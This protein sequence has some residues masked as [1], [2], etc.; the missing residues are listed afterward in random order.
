MD[1][2]EKLDNALR[3]SIDNFSGFHDFTVDTYDLIDTKSLEKIECSSNTYDEYIFYLWDISPRSI[4][5]RPINSNLYIL[6]KQDFSDKYS[7]LLSQIESFLSSGNKKPQNISPTLLNSVLYTISISL[8]IA[9]DIVLESQGAR[10]NVGERFGDFIVSLFKKLDITHSTEIQPYG[11]SRIDLIMSPHSS[12]Q[13]G[14]E[15][16]D[17]DEVFC[18]VKYSSKDR[19]K[20]IFSDKKDLEDACGSKIKMVAIFNHDV[21]R[22]GDDGVAKTFVP[23][24]FKTRYQSNSLSGVYH[25]DLPRGFDDPGIKGK[26]LSF[27][28]FMLNDIWN[29]I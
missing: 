3:N 15:N 21:Q 2:D 26:L 19:F 18:S 5:T 4:Q 12:I 22:A 7:E 16:V 28:E 23:N 8:G 1:Y 11:K 20:H 17:T 25:F 13:S 24:I 14:P 27:D 29:L 10:K 6:E 9:G